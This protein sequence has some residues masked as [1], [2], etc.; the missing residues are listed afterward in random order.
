MTGVEE[1]SDDDKLIDG[2]AAEEAPGPDGQDAGDTPTQRY[3]LTDH[4]LGDQHFMVTD[5][6]VRETF[7]VSTF[8]GLQRGRSRWAARFRGDGLDGPSADPLKTA[9][10]IRRLA[11][12]ARWM[13]NGLFPGHRG[14]PGFVLGEATH[15]IVLEFALS[16]EEKPVRVWQDKNI[17]EIEDSEEQERQTVYPTVEGGRYLGTLLATAEDPDKLIERFGVV[18]KQAV[19]T[20]QGALREFVDFGVELD[21]LVPVLEDSGESDLRRVNMPIEKSQQEL[22]VLQRVPEE[23]SDTF[24]VEGLLYTQ[25]SL[26]AEFGI[27][28]DNGQHVIG[29]YDLTVADKLGPAWDKRVWAR[30]REDGPKQDWMPRAGRTRRVLVDVARLRKN[31]TR[32]G[33]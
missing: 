24:E 3:G 33:S 14:V 5:D 18:G 20:Y 16:P 9:A 23:A 31:E 27:Q 26:K 30:I 15:S 7:G 25:N 19:L 28:K 2:G 4:A 1:P 11:I 32:L 12:T 21:L 29:E 13:A 6:E 10:L 22:E 17:E 8:E